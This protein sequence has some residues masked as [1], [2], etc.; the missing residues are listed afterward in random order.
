M[1]SESGELKC[2]GGK[3]EVITEFLMQTRRMLTTLGRILSGQH[4]ES[5]FNNL[6]RRNICI[7]HES[8]GCYA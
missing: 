1:R 5:S 3:V 6:N 7:L 2:E 8:S 4:Q